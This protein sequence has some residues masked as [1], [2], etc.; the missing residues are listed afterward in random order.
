MDQNLIKTSPKQ[1]IFIGIIAVAMLGSMIASYIAI[2]L[3]NNDTSASSQDIDYELIAKYESEYQAA[4]NAVSNA[5]TN[6]F[7]EFV[8]YKSRVAAYNEST[9]NS[10]GIQIDDLKKGSGRTLKDGDT[11]YLAY[12]VGWCADETVFDSSFDNFDNPTKFKGVL[13]AS[14]GLI[15][16]WNTGVVGMKLGGIREITIPG[17]LAY[18]DTQEICGGTYKP[19]KFIVMAVENSGELKA[20]AD[21]FALAQTKLQY[22]YYGIDYETM[23]NATVETDETEAE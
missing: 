10:N 2:V 13:N 16:G 9:A 1:R 3:A 14:N 7:K 15:E 5:S 6:Y 11:D 23:T 20:A 21:N 18:K 8:E 17:E 19:L 4:S 12:Y 22:A